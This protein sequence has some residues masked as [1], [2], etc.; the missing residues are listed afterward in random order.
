MFNVQFLRDKRTD[1]MT[2]AQVIEMFPEVSAL[3]LAGD[4]CTNICVKSAEYGN[5][6]IT[7]GGT[8]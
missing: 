2:F 4:L 7:K 3:L 1:S 8:A 5:V 6:I